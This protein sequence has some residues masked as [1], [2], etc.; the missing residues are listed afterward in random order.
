M[1]NTFSVHSQ[2]ISKM[3][4]EIEEWGCCSS[5]LSF[6]YKL[7][8]FVTCKKC[9]LSEGDDGSVIDERNC[10]YFCACCPLRTLL[11]IIPGCCV[12]WPCYSCACIVNCPTDF[13]GH[14]AS[15]HGC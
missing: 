1:Y 2:H 7:H 12:F 10:C 13:A 3:Q 5:Y 15:N 11:C 4:K 8:E 14:V 9:C 6:F